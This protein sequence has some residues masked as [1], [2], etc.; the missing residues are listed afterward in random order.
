MNLLKDDDIELY[1]LGGD[2]IIVINVPMARREYKPIFINDNLFGGTFRRNGEGDY[3]CT[4]QEVRA[5]LRDATE[6]TSDMKVLDQFDLS[7][8]VFIVWMIHRFIKPCG[9]H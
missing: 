6:E 3:H 4:P 9:K 5:M 1:T 8:M 7:L 2:L